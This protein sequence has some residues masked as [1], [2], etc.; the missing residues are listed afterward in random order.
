[1]QRVAGVL[2][3]VVVVGRRE[4]DVDVELVAVGLHEARRDLVHHPLDTGE[5]L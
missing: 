5:V 2:Q 4:Q 1:V 3:H